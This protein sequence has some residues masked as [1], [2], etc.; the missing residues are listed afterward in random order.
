MVRHSQ[1]TH[2]PRLPI[3]PTVPHPTLVTMQAS[4]RIGHR[5]RPSGVKCQE[6]ILP[7]LHT[8]VGTHISSSP[9]SR[10][11]IFSCSVAEIT[12]DRKWLTMERDASTTKRSRGKAQTSQKFS[13]AVYREGSR[14][15]LGDYVARTMY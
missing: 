8:G 14:N 12:D 15:E 4:L 11:S 1:V 7:A 13:S 6:P 10:V 9:S 5:T 2:G 3:G